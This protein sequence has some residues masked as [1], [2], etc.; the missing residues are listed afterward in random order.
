MNHPEAVSI[1][2]LHNDISYV[3]LANSERVMQFG[4]EILVAQEARKRRAHADASERWT[5]RPYFTRVVEERNKMDELGCW[6]VVK[7]LYV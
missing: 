4:T 3:L 6:G 2:L 1:N 7:K 5:V